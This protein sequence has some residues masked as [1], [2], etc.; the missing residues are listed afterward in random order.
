MKKSIQMLAVIAAFSGLLLA[1]STPAEKVTDAEKDVME[2]EA[3][4]ELTQEQYLQDVEDFKR[5]N[6]EKI[7]A[8]EAAI[9][10]FNARVEDQKAETKEDYRKKIA[11]LEAKNADL[12]SRI[13]DVKADSKAGWGRF[14]ADFNAEMDDL[15]ESFREMGE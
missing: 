6:N 1:C 9:S 13:A 2:A 8:N 15:G 14:K 4:L 5:I 11:D 12:K 3:A 10:D 7:T